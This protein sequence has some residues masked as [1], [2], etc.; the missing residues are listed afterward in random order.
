MAVW[1]IISVVGDTTPAKMKAPTIKTR[2]FFRRDFP[3][4]NPR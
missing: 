1:V 2:L 4:T 3:V